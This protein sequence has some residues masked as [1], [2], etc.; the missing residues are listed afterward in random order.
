MDLFHFDDETKTITFL[1]CVGDFEMNNNDTLEK[2]KNCLSVATNFDFW[3]ECSNM[4]A[5]FVDFVVSNATSVKKVVFNDLSLNLLHLIDKLPKVDSLEIITSFD[6]LHKSQVLLL[7]QIVERQIKNLRLKGQY[8]LDLSSP[9]EVR[10]FFKCLCHVEGLTFVGGIWLEKQYLADVIESNKNLKR[11]ALEETVI[12]TLEDDEDVEAMEVVYETISKSNLEEFRFIG[13]KWGVD[14]DL[15]N[16]VYQFIKALSNVTTMK[17]L[18]L[19]YNDLGFD[20]NP[21]V[22]YLCQMIPRLQYLE[23]S[24]S[25]GDIQDNDLYF[26]KFENFFN[27][28]EHCK[29]LKVL[30]LTLYCDDLFED[31]CKLRLLVQFFIKR[32]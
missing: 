30:K 21:V 26:E 17:V 32:Y 29:S 14:E 3:K 18:T 7:G 11:L 24:I 12:G 5:P 22:K 1:R 20:A 15:D 2:L 16:V 10:A 13:E 28:L 9:E 23:L 4:S 31:D 19:H 8:L 25:C 6:P 27:C